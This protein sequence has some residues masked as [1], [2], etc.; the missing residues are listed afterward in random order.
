MLGAAPARAPD[1]WSVGD[2]T[3]TSR[4][5]LGTAGYPSPQVLREAIAASGTQV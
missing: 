2:V 4:F 1:T 3:L 5:L